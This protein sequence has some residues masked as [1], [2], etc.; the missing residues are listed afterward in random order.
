MDRKNH[1]ESVEEIE[2]EIKRILA[3]SDEEVLREYMAMDSLSREAINALMDAIVLT[4]LF[5]S[6][7]S[8][9]KIV[10][11]SKPKDTMH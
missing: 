6:M 4:A 1:P 10:R 5:S 9:I 3:M 7:P 11:I 2:A 8:S